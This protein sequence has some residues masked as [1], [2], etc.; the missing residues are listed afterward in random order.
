MS[1]ASDDHR[2]PSLNTPEPTQDGGRFK[3]NLEEY[4]MEG[5]SRLPFILS[6]TEM[7]LLGIAGVRFAGYFAHTTTYSLRFSRL[8]SS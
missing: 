3:S 5:D 1:T 2:S 8:V 6:R 7:K 4:E